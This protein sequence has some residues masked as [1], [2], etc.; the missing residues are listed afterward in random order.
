MRHRDFNLYWV[1]VVFSQIGTRGTIA[2]QLFHVYLLTGSTVQ[3]GFVGLSQAVALL[4]LSPLGG[5]YADRIDRRK[6]L[7]ASQM[8]AMVVSLAIA[9][10]TLSGDVQPWHIYVSVVLHTAAATFDQPARQALIPAM[11]PREEL[12]HAFALLN[13]SREVAILV[14]PALAGGLISVRG[15]EA[16]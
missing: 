13:P 12:V 10:L 2:A 14:G 6:L 1:G 4:V 3:V 5:A 8:V 11:V 7:Q 15:P 16:K 9:V